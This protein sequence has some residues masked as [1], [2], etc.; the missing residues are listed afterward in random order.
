[1]KSTQKIA[2]RPPKLS[3]VASLLRLMNSLVEEKAMLAMQKN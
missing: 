1:M 3:D 2:I